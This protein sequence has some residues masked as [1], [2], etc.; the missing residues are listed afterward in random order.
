LKQLIQ[1]DDVAYDNIK[2]LYKHH[3]DRQTHP[4][5][6]HD[7]QEALR[8]ETKRYSKVFI[9]VD[10]LDECSEAETRRKL[11]TA[12]RSLGSNVNLMFTSRVLSSI[13][14]DFHGTE[15]LDIRASEHDMQKY[16][17]GRV[18]HEGLLK[19]HIDRDQKLQEEIVKKIIENA[20]G[21]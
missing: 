10:A 17:E 19:R 3:K 6:F 7:L 21:M 18:S 1:D 9:V 15:R 5:K 14:L 4:T 13:E 20:G 8:S 11:L 12:L 2:S 16:I